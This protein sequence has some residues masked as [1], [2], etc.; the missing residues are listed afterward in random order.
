MFNKPQ[1]HKYLTNLALGT[2]LGFALTAPQVLAET[3]EERGL[4]IISEADRRDD[5]YGDSTATMKMTLKNRHGDS[6]SREMRM[7]TKEV[8]D[9][10]LGDKALIVF[11]QPR[12]VKGT[13]LLSFTKIIDP[14]DQWLYL[15]AL[16]RV[17]R[18]ASVNK[19]GPFVGSEFAFEDMASQEVGKYTYKY[20]RNET[21]G[22]M[23]CFV[24][25]SY[26]RYKHSG[27]TRLIG[28]LDTTEYRTQKIEY[29]DRKNALLKTLLLS[30][31]HQYFDRYWR[32]HSLV[33]QNHQSGKVSSIVWS[34]MK[35][36]VGL[37]DS[38]FTKNAL[39]RS[40]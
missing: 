36:Q 13:A 4:A 18:I 25:E 27:Y 5:G 35:L 24:V 40:K 33:M 29:Y 28:W 9:K 38:D 10:T 32:P 1:P 16:K 12:D 30:D 14:D 34:D 37:K 39:K 23:E 3:A 2:L 11:D 19:S 7:K 31:Y 21:C 20:L 22:E 8:L 15:P 17:K 26:P 6:S